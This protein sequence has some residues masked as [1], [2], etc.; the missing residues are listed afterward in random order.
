MTAGW[1]F[2]AG[3]ANLAATPAYWYV[4]TRLYERPVPARAR[5]PSAQFSILWWGLGLTGA[6]TGVGSLV[7]SVGALTYA[8]G[9]TLYLLM[10][11]G[12]CV[13]LWGMVGYLLYIYT[14]RYHLVG[15]TAGYA[16]F[17][18]IVLYWV[19]ASGPIGVSFATGSLAIQYSHMVGGLILLLVIVGLIFPEFIAAVLYLSLLP[20]THD[21][22]LRFRIAMVSAAVFLFFAVAFFTPA[23]DVAAL[24]RAVL[25]VGSAGLALFAY[26]P[27]EALQR[28]LGVAAVPPE[29]S[30]GEVSV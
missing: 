21:R 12:D 28:W 1:L 17:Y 19:N 18:V 23:G 10:V 6:I 9:F 30:S 26:F 8:L 3:V 25:D 14:G 13:L 5:L 22:T 2:A 11:I 15:L 4:G 29:R 7:A 16:A 20:R 24:V 27:P